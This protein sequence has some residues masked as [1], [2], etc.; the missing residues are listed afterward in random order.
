MAL[1]LSIESI[2]LDI[3]MGKRPDESMTVSTPGPI[4]LDTTTDWEVTPE[5]FWQ[6]KTYPLLQ[7]S[8]GSM[9]PSTQSLIQTAEGTV[10]IK[11][12]MDAG[13]FGTNPID[14]LPLVPTKFHTSRSMLDL[15][16]VLSSTLSLWMAPIDSLADIINP[17]KCQDDYL[18]FLAAGIGATFDSSYSDAQIRQLII[19]APEMYKNK[20][21]RYGL[22]RLANGDYMRHVDLWAASTSDYEDGTFKETDPGAGAY[23]TPHANVYCRLTEEDAN[24]RLLD[25]NEASKVAQFQTEYERCRP[26]TVYP[27][28][29]VFVSGRVGA[30]DVRV[31][32]LANVYATMNDETGQLVATSLQDIIGSPANAKW[33]LFYNS[34][35]QSGTS[36]SCD[37]VYGLDG[38]VTWYRVAVTHAAVSNFYTSLKIWSS[39]V[40]PETS[41]PFLTLEFPGIQSSANVPTRFEVEVPASVL[42]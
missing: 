24:D 32:N 39:S 14:L 35:S 28:W 5:V 8:L 41:D 19:D 36:V 7:R 13:V 9:G 33:K 3:G 26:V 22:T 18:P 21:S 10:V 6:L 29:R 40:N 31:E 30:V 11:G 1:T 17:S 34:G 15:V 27:H 23:R 2:Y 38:T 37:P 4:T 20:G 42:A 12:Y 16:D 25:A